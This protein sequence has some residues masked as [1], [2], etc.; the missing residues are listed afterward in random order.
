MGLLFLWPVLLVVAILIKVKMPGGPVLFVQKRVG[1]DGEL[2]DCHKFRT[3]R[4]NDKVDGSKFK[5]QG[6]LKKLIIRKADGRLLA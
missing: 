4:V 1:K 5:V 3:I 6:G 2:F